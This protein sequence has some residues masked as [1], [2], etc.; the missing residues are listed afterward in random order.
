MAYKGKVYGWIME[1]SDSLENSVFITGGFF[2]TDWLKT[3]VSKMLI[4]GDVNLQA[5]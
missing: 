1:H 2:P 5:S 3:I 4:T